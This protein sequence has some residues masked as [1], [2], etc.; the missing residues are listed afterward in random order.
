MAGEAQRHPSQVTKRDA[1]SLAQWPSNCFSL[2]IHKVIW[3]NNAHPGT[4]LSQHLNISR[5]SLNSCKEYN[6]QNNV[7]IYILK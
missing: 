6:F 3:K 1:V 4:F 2:C 5:A 7:N